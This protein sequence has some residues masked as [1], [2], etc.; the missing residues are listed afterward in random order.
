M[1]LTEAAA[2]LA[3]GTGL[4][5]L[6]DASTDGT[7]IPVGNMLGTVAY[8]APE[9]FKDSFVTKPSDVYAFGILSK[10]AQLLPPS[11][12]CAR[13]FWP[14]GAVQLASW[15]CSARVSRLQCLA[16]SS[17]HVADCCILL[18]AL[19]P[20]QEASV[21]ASLAQPIPRQQL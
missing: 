8:T 12:L 14:P 3:V 11:T 18:A 5:R 17:C 21:Y 2:D 10:L 20:L 13:C 1:Q 4:S 6:L 19:G 16:L 15:G 7:S 9:V